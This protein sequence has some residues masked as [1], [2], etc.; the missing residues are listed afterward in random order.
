MSILAIRV[1]DRFALA[2]TVSENSYE[3]SG[4]KEKPILKQRNSNILFVSLSK[5]SPERRFECYLLWNKH[6]IGIRTVLGQN[7]FDII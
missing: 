6:H 5:H 3:N 1:Q 4:E 7:Q 2:G